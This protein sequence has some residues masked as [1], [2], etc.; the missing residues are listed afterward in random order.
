MTPHKVSYLEIRLGHLASSN[1]DLS[2][3]LIHSGEERLKISKELIQG[4]QKL[5]MERDRLMRK[6]QL[7]EASIKLNDKNGKHLMEEYATLKKNYLTLVE[8][9][10]TGMAQ[11]EELSAELLALA[12]AQD[13]LRRQLEEQQQRVNTTTPELYRELERV[14]TLISGMSHNRVKPEDLAALNKE[15]KNLEKSLLENQDKIKDMLKMKNS[16][17]EQQK[18][19][20][21]KIGFVCCVSDVVILSCG[22]WSLWSGLCLVTRV[23]MGKEQK[24]SKKEIHVGPEKAALMCS[25]SQLKIVEDENSKL[26]LQLKELNEEYRAR[27]VCYLQDLADYVDKHGKEKR[28]PEQNKMRPFVDGMLQDIC[29][30][31]R[32]RKEQLASAARSY[33]KRLQRT[34]RT[35]HALLIAYSTQREQIMAHPENGLDPGPPEAHFSLEP[36]ELKDE[37]EQELQHLC[38]DKARLEGQLQVAKKQ[39]DFE[40]EQ[41]VL[42]TRAAVAKVWVVRQLR[43]LGFACFLAADSHAPS[44]CQC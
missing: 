40:K 22:F 41:A 23:V 4:G 7:T 16:H 24:E 26:Q 27:L 18:K 36:S 25:L 44:S 30:S 10:D 32:V 14:Q 6:I 28:P 21:E 43:A 37:T 1:M 35:H 42:M 11:S 2:C 20:E 3:R 12:E 9:H 19:L 5:E 33:K 17:E 15:Q 38:R 39:I 34:T 13:S 31:Y 8:A 29:S